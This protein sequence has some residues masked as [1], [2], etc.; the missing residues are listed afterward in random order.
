MGLNNMDYLCVNFY[1]LMQS[2]D[3][4]SLPCRF[5]LK[6][7]K[8]MHTVALRTEATISGGEMPANLGQ[9]FK[10]IWCKFHIFWCFME[11]LSAPPPPLQKKTYLIFNTEYWLEIFLLYR[12]TWAKCLLTMQPWCLTLL[13]PQLLSSPELVSW[14][15][16]WATIGLLA[17]F[18]LLQMSEFLLSFSPKTVMQWGYCLHGRL[19]YSIA[20]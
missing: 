10:V 1:T 2:N 19:W 18:L 16:Y 6:A 4:I 5:P 7:V 17:L 12:I 20:Y 8:V 11:S 3:M 14:L 9:A 15:L 13:E